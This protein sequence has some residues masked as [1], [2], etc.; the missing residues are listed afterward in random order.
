MTLRTG[1]IGLGAQGGPIVE[2]MLQQGVDVGLWA[3][4][5]ESLEPFL[6]K[7][8]KRAETPAALARERNSVGIC[9]L[10]DND[11]REVVLGDT[12]VLS[13]MGP[14]GLMMI[15]STVAPDTVIELD[16]LAREKGVHLLDAPVSGGARGA[17]AGTMT[18]MVGGETSALDIARPVLESFATNI[19]HLGTV[20]AGQMMKLLNNTLCYA[21]MVLSISALELA[22]QLG[23]DRR[24]A[25]EIMA[26]ELRPQQRSRPR[27]Q[28]R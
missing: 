23:I 5:P 22:E 10:S 27:D 24:R 1:F 15:H 7:G 28:R 16:R 11:V 9:V 25:G 26:T 3:R 20:G 17:L 4:R 19:P 13:G 6:P 8:A 21:N 12:G 14:G 2:R 18:V